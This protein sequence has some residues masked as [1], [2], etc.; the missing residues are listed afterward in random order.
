MKKAELC[1]AIA[2]CG[3]DCIHCP[4]YE[5]NITDET[6]KKMMASTG[7]K[8]EEVVCHGCRSGERSHICPSECATA[9]CAKEMGVDFCFECPDFP[10][11]KLSP[12]SDQAERL[13]HNL[14]VY[15][16]CRMK[17]M[18]TEKWLKEESRR[19]WV[20]YFKGKMIIGKGPVLETD[21]N[22]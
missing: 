9:S 15:N 4:L 19:S 11:E 3:L 1:E 10:C 14:K 2:P 5:K 13:P 7:L 21:Q 8:P 18:G 6:R 16:S 12:A 22:S 20:R 17:R